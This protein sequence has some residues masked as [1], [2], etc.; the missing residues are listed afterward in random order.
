MVRAEIEQ[1]DGSVVFESREPECGEDF[2]DLC[3]DC[4]YC[5]GHESCF[6]G[7]IDNGPHRWYVYNDDYWKDYWDARR[8]ALLKEQT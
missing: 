3:G 4:L 5:Y 6:D 8:Q 1:S 7:G 2:C